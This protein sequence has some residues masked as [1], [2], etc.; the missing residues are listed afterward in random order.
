MGK[1]NRTTRGTDTSPTSDSGD[2]AESQ[3]TV[4]SDTVAPI[5]HTVR[6]WA[7]QALVAAYG[8]NTHRL[9]T[10]LAELLQASVAYVDRPTV[11]AHL[12]RPL[13]DGEWAAVAAQSAHWPS[14]STS[15]TPARSAPTGSR[16]DCTAPASPAA[17]SAPPRDRVPPGSPDRD[18]GPP[19]LPGL[20][21]HRR[22]RQHPARRRP[23]SAALLRQTPA[24]PR[25]GRSPRRAPPDAKSARVH[26]SPRPPPPRHPGRLRQGPLPLPRLHR[27]QHRRQP[28]HPGTDLPPLTP[29]RRRRPR[30][31]A[32][33][34]AARGRHRR[35]AH[36]PTG[37][38]LGQPH[39]RVHR[40]RPRRLP[41][42]AAGPPGHGHPDPGHRASTAPAGRRAAASTPPAPGVACKR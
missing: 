31:R 11:E 36:R 22:L 23:P 21:L 3:A 13:S 37:R 19:D 34:R 18:E 17:P 41:G 35:R 29:L 7:L 40:A 4:A 16:T 8:G 32:H 38:P 27:R 5:R 39:P 10:D 6:P 12:E 33:R 28:H 24:R 2:A 26:P 14:T 15:A 30:P 9:L 20:R 42:N 1:Q 25:A